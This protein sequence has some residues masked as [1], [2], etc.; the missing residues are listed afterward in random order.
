MTQTLAHG[1]YHAFPSPLSRDI[2]RQDQARRSAERRGDFEEASR[3]LDRKQQILA[4]F[5][6]NQLALRRRAAAEAP[7]K[8]GKRDPLSTFPERLRRAA[9]I[10]RDIEQAH[11]L[12]LGPG[13]ALDFVEGGQSAGMEALIDKRRSGGTAWRVAFDA[14]AEAAHLQ[15][16]YNV[17]V[18]RCSI[19]SQ[20]KM[21][22]SRVERKALTS[23]I[24]AALEAA[25]SFYDL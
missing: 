14:I 23:D 18:S 22:T 5:A 7:P 2:E 4:R 15:T 21:A 25:A 9:D 3:C 10:L 6:Q 11:T 17:I 12:R 1:V 13:F 20:L 8:P 19:A 24:W 16:V